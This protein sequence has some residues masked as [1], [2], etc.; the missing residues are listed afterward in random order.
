MDT[1]EKNRRSVP[2]ESEVHVDDRT[3]RC[4]RPRR[5]DERLD[6]RAGPQLLDEFGGREVEDAPD[7]FAGAPVPA[8]R[9]LAPPSSRCGSGP[10]RVRGSSAARCPRRGRLEEPTSAR[11]GAAHHRWCA[12][13]SIPGPSPP[14]ERDRAGRASD[15]APPPPVRGSDRPTAGA[16]RG[17]RSQRRGAGHCGHEGV[18]RA[19]PRGAAPSRGSAS[20]D[21][22]RGSSCGEKSSSQP[23]RD[24]AGSSPAPGASS[25]PSRRT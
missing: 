20:I 23:R 21:P 1:T 7:R 14:R 17:E 9:A 16:D 3:G 22:S 11:T 2:A 18:P 10:A 4:N 25:A 5:D 8:M 15:R 6:V 12:G 19:R 24:R 13:G